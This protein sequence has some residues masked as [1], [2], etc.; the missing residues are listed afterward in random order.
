MVHNMHLHGWFSLLCI[1]KYNERSENSL[2]F[3]GE[4]M[5][6]LILMQIRFIGLKK[7]CLVGVWEIGDLQWIDLSRLVGKGF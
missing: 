7:M 5:K 1:A 2:P 3:V 4:I 6:I